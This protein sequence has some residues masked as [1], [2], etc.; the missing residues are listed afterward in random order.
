[1]R[2]AI[3]E[4]ATSEEPAKVGPGDTQHTRFKPLKPGV[5]FSF[6]VYFENLSDRELG[7]LCWTLHPHDEQGQRYCHHLGMG[8]PLGMGAVELHARLHIIDRPLRYGTL[9]NGSG[10]N[11]QLGESATSENSS[12]STQPTAG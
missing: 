10:D 11:W 2:T 5:Q 7:A 3:S 1:M 4:E 12:E 6:R 9:F 8:K